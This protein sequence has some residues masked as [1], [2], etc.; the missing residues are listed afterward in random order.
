MP[1]QTITTGDVSFM[2]AF[3]MPVIF[4]VIVLKNYRMANCKG[5]AFVK[6]TR[7][8]VL[9]SIPCMIAEGIPR[10]HAF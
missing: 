6:T 4:P 5:F 2:L 9:I 8:E 3:W 1:T 10:M 7:R